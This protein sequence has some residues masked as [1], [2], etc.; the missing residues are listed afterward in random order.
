MISFTNNLLY[1]SV[2]TQILDRLPA[3]FRDRV[4]C[5]YTNTSR[6]LKLA[7]IVNISNWYFE[8]VVFPGEKLLFEALPEAE[9]EIY[10]GVVSTIV[11]AEVVSCDRLTMKARQ[12]KVDHNM[13]AAEETSRK[14]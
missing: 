10:A 3:H 4:L 2:M 5:C 9:L 12:E 7:R 14:Y 13:E 6:E 11:P 8:R 1:K